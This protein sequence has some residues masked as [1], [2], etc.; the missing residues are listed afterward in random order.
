MAVFPQAFQKMRTGRHRSAMNYIVYL[1]TITLSAV[2]KLVPWP[3]VKAI[4]SIL[5]TVVYYGIP[6][7]K[8][9]VLSN[10]VRTLKTNPEETARIAR[11]SYI[12]TIRVF[13]DTL[14]FSHS[15]PPI[16]L[17]IE[18]NLTEA[19]KKGNGVILITGHIGNWELAG[20]PVGA[21]GPTYA[22]GRRIKNPYLDKWIRENRIRRGI[23]PIYKTSTSSSNR[24]LLKA[25]KNN[26]I[27]ILV[28]DQYRPGGHET[29]FMGIK[30]R[31]PEGPARLAKLTKAAVIP[32]FM[33]IKDG[34]YEAKVYPEIKMVQD[35]DQERE[36][37]LN[38]RNY[39]LAIERMIRECPEQ[40]FWFHN[41]FKNSPNTES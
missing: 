31:V 5:G 15:M 24:Q 14:K 16:K 18:E 39:M 30:T 32:A 12:N 20:T 37:A 6:I 7:R 29:E 23:V 25:L 36:L 11:A 10:I 21:I 41:R 22:V 19:L 4:A 33:P 13:L 38:T 17:P 34:T 28:I 27:V 2:L 9:T 1:I 35:N 8:K 40:W 26:A 3:I